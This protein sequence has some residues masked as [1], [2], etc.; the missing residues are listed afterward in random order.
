MKP[1]TELTG[2]ETSIELLR[3]ILVPAAAVFVVFALRQLAGLLMPPALAQPPGI[4]PA[5]LSD[6]QR[7]V[8]PRLLGC[9]MAAAF[10]VVGAKTAPRWRHTTALVLAGLW[11]AYSLM[12][13]VLVH[14]GR[15]IPHYTDFVL[16]IV[17][18]AGAAAYIWYS[19]KSRGVT[20]AVYTVPEQ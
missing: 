6:L 10:V 12:D 7:F 11:I 8:L 5:T 2:K 3:W 1:L 13:H 17:S 19:E 18:A 16:A 14:L 4:S 9:L 20:A 15:G